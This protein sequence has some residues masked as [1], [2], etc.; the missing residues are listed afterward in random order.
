MS[1]EAIVKR[2]RKTR[3]GKGF[4]REELREVGSSFSEAL[5]RGI[6]IDTRRSTKHEEN[7]TKLKAYSKAFRPK[8]PSSE[9]KAEIVELAE[10]KGVGSR[11]A[12]KLKEADIGNANELA[13]ST[14]Q[15]VAEAIGS[16]EKRATNLID[17]ARS[18]L[19][20]T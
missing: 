13:A 7:V 5:R 15:I 8:P 3:K 10:V 19:K 14:P 12:E 18:L 6:P 11:T 4:S 9:K 1:I 20:E 17:E 2:K 16:S